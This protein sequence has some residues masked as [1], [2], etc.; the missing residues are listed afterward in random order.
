MF[1]VIQVL[2]IKIFYVI[3]SG[4]FNVFCSFYLGRGF[5]FAIDSRGV[6]LLYFWF[7]LLVMGFGWYL[8]FGFE[9]LVFLIFGRDKE[10]KLFQ[11]LKS[12]ISV[13]S[14]F[15][16]VVV[17]IYIG[18]LYSLFVV[19]FGMFRVFV[20]FFLLG[21]VEKVRKLLFFVE[22]SIEDGGRGIFR[23]GYL[24]EVGYQMS[25]IG[26]DFTVYVGDFWFGRYTSSQ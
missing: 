10:W 3:D 14:S 18:K 9:V 22:Q 4:F 2:K 5:I 23:R 21:F 11:R 26:E 20:A 19:V 1:K 24:G 16:R 8:G 13:F 17:F 6:D 12:F 25:W 15:Y 7:L